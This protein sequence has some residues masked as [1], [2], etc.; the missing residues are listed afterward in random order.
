MDS[1]CCVSM[2]G[3]RNIFWMVRGCTLMRSASH[4]L[5]WPCRRSSSLI[6]CPIGICI[7]KPRAFCRAR[8]SGLPTNQTR[9]LTDAVSDLLSADWCQNLSRIRAAHYKHNRLFIFFYS[10]YYP[11]IV[12]FLIIYIVSL[13]LLYTANIHIFSICKKYIL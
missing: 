3:L 7:K 12:L 9:K 1:N 2:V 6:I 13:Q 11:I 5:V 10:F 8:G 4:S